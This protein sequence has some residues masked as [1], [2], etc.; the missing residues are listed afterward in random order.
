VKF[1]KWAGVKS[2]A[3]KK[4]L[5][6][7]AVGAAA[8]GAA[9]CYWLFRPLPKTDLARLA[10]GDAL[11]FV[12][13]G[14]LP[15]VLNDLQTT[16]FWERT[17]PAIGFPDQLA[18]V[19]ESAGALRQLNLGPDEAVILSRAQWALAVTG[20]TV[21]GKG[22]ETSPGIEVSVTPR[23]T[24]IMHPRSSPARMARAVESRLPL[25]ARKIFGAD[26]AAAETPGRDG[27]I[28]RFHKP[29]QPRTLL[30]AVRGDVAFFSNDEASLQACLD[31]QSARRASLSESDALAR[32]RRAV[33]GDDATVFAYVSPAGL[34]KLAQVGLGVLPD[35]SAV[36]GSVSVNGQERPLPDAAMAGLT[37]GLAYGARVENKRV[38]DRYHLLLSPELAG[39]L[40]AHFVA[41]RKSLRALEILP[42]NVVSYTTLVIRRPVDMIEE[43]QAAVSARTN[44][45]VAFL[46]R[47][48]NVA[49]RDRY[50]LGP[51]ETLENVLGEEMAIASL[52][53]RSS[54][55]CLIE[56]R[57]RVRILP[58]L[59]R[60][61]RAAKFTLKNESY[62][63]A[64]LVVSAHPDKRAA[65]FIGDF[66]AVG[67]AEQL[68][69]LIDAQADGV[70]LSKSPSAPF[71]APAAGD[72]AFM[73]AMRSDRAELESLTL[74]VAK[75]AHAGDATRARLADPAVRE[76]LDAQPAALSKTELRA[77]GIYTET[78]SAA[79]NFARLASFVGEDAP[80]VGTPAPAASERTERPPARR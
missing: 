20:F 73:H 71:R 32:G 5:L 28:L 44:A 60:Y 43:A 8:V 23:C 41:D 36:A 74:A 18:Y 14:D 21:E 12:E 56:V 40:R 24:L 51:R 69:V 33:Q 10:P 46:L 29:G 58:V 31:A 55:V 79:G 26:V 49:M 54:A 42:A 63:G 3:F 78:R 53:E 30:V 77:D 9:Y 57:D 72:G 70:T 52:D 2:S 11:A 62:R 59:D 27:P 45:A 64:D 50:G 7:V 19:G 6:I 35:A 47:Q 1:V 4:A 66:L 15:G 80:I 13:F 25:L 61:L 75:L 38:T 16:E 17:R 22:S 76:A 39:R 65:C 48:L 67:T 34:S 37:D 68:H